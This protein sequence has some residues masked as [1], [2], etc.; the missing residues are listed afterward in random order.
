[1]C[2]QSEESIEHLFFECPWTAAVWKKVQE[3]S[4]MYRGQSNWVGS[5]QHGEQI[6]LL[7]KLTGSSYYNLSYLESKEWSHT[8]AGY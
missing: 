4:H 2:R 8:Y 5:M 6:L 1:M 7:I 3:F